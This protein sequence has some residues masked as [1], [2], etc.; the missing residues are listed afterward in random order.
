MPDTMLPM[1][2]AS[3]PMESSNF[4]VYLQFEVKWLS[5]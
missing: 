4:M 1:P 5:V 2:L 3:L